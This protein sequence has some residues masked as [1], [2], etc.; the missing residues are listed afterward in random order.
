MGN[1]GLDNYTQFV[2]LHYSYHITMLGN[3]TDPFCMIEGV[4]R[5]AVVDD[6][7]YGAADNSQDLSLKYQRD[8]KRSLFSPTCKQINAAMP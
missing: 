5:L 2:V 4:G 1:D 7:S 3:L 6:S 8:A